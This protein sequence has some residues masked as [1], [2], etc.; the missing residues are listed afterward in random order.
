MVEIY[1][2]RV[3]SLI[4]SVPLQ[5][6]ESPT[7]V[8]CCK[9]ARNA[10]ANR[11]TR[12]QEIIVVVELGKLPQHS[13]HGRLRTQRHLVF[14]WNKNVQRSERRSIRKIT[15]TNFLSYEHSHG[16]LPVLQVGK[17][18][19]NRRR[20]DEQQLPRQLDKKTPPTAL[21]KIPI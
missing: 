3:V 9:S 2:Y 11:I 4:N 13:S 19:L 18:H 1:V 16:F 20:P 15:P 21:S 10:D 7:I 17:A 12:K 6:S 8:L 5:H 14:G